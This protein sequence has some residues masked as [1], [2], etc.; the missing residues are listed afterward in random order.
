MTTDN[1]EPKDCVDKL[2]MRVDNLEALIKEMQPYLMSSW[3]TR[4]TAPPTSTT[5]TKDVSA[6]EKYMKGRKK[7]L[8]GTFPANND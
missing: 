7:S 3:H 5:P 4:P 2:R 8:R 1:D 6:L